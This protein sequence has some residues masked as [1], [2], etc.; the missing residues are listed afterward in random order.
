MQ[1]G[2]Y[3]TSL[4]DSSS[5]HS[6]SR[7]LVR[8]CSHWTASIIRLYLRC[9]MHL[10]HAVHC[11]SARKTTP[12]Q[13]LPSGHFSFYGIIWNCLPADRPIFDNH[14]RLFFQ[15]SGSTRGTRVLFTE[16]IQ[17]LWGCAITMRIQVIEMLHALAF[18]LENLGISVMIASSKAQPSHNV[19]I[20]WLYFAACHNQVV[21]IPAAMYTGNFTFVPYWEV[22]VL[23]SKQ[24]QWLLLLS[25]YATWRLCHHF[26]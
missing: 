20:T 12:G 13:E 21:P 2:C 6:R 10:H 14:W 24:L 4:C 8:H 5:R 16:Q 15:A 11:I 25:F 7:D 22:Q 1:P 3:G 26:R 17:Y 23:K 18:L 19:F 9:Q